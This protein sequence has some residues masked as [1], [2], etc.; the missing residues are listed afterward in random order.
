MLRT[1]PS[2]A[3]GELIFTLSSGKGER[4]RNPQ[5]PVNHVEYQKSLAEKTSE[6]VLLQFGD[7]HRAALRRYCQFVKNGIA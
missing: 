7:T 3:V 5:N 4:K 6:D 1:K 2:P